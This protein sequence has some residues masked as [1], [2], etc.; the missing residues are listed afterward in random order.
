MCSLGVAKTISIQ[1]QR[2]QL[3]EQAA[4]KEDL[5]PRLEEV[6]TQIQRRNVGAQVSDRAIGLVV[7]LAIADAHAIEDQSVDA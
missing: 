2:M 7:G 5:I 3:W 6:T 4:E 1:G